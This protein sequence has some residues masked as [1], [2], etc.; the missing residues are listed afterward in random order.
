MGSLVVENIYPG[1]VKY[2]MSNFY[3]GD[4]Q[5]GK[6]NTQIRLGGGGGE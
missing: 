4:N 5:W 1:V 3:K 2:V 6:V